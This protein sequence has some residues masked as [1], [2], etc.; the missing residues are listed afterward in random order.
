MQPFVVVTHPLDVLPQPFALYASPLFSSWRRIAAPMES[1]TTPVVTMHVNLR[2][3]GI[4]IPL[5][6][7]AYPTTDTLDH[8]AHRGRYFPMLPQWPQR[9]FQACRILQ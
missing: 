2:A 6:I 3:T 5:N 9:A 7:V 4:P 8:F 1:V